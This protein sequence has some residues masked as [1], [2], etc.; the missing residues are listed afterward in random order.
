MYLLSIFG[1]CQNL[2]VENFDTFIPSDEIL[3][4]LRHM[5]PDREVGRVSRLM[6]PVAHPEDPFALVQSTDGLIPSEGA[7]A[8]IGAFVIESGREISSHEIG[9]PFYEAGNFI[10]L[11]ECPYGEL[12]E[13]MRNVADSYRAEPL[14]DQRL[15]DFICEVLDTMAGIAES[16]DPDVTLTILHLQ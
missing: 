4:S 6:I 12:I 13:G 14:A 7:R 9:R 16:G 11:N 2:S 10:F 5:F 1:I 8:C 3:A 15:T